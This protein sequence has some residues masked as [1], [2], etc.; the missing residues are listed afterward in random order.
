MKTLFLLLT[1]LLLTGTVAGQRTA[2]VSS[3]QSN[4]VSISKTPPVIAWKA[5]EAIR[6]TVTQAAVT[7]KACIQSADTVLTYQVLHNGRPAGGLQRGYKR[8]VCGQEI[9]ADLQ[10]APGT[11]E[12]LIKATN[13]VGTTTSELRIITFLVEKSPTALQPAAQKRLALVLANS[14]YKRQALKNPVNDGRL[15]KTQLEN[16]GFTVTYKENLPLQELENTISDFLGS[17]SGNNIGLVYYAG[18]GLMVNGDNYLQPVD[19]DPARESDVRFKCYSMHQLIAGMEDAN[20][21]GTNLIFWDA[22][23]NNPY[24][25]WR[26]GPDD[27]V[28]APMHPATGTYIM[29]AT[30]PGQTADDGDEQ[31]GLFTSELVKHINKPNVDLYDLPDLIDQGLQERGYY[32]RPYHEGDLRGRFYFLRAN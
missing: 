20:R 30:R 16:L 11:N 18:H 13:S 17:L 1:G 9:T 32:Q 25:S 3:A 15:M 2:T 5:P 14:T 23:R 8:V 7:V 4:W 31:N 27:R 22:C 6:T 26:R 29:Y 10:L 12:L 24:R 28:Y 21:N 19:A